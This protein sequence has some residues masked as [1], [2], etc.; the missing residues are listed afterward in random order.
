MEVE[1]QSGLLCCGD[2]AVGCCLVAR[3]VHV[4]TGHL[5]LRLDAIATSH[6]RVCVVSVVVAGLDN[7]D[8]GFCQL[9]L[10]GEFLPEEAEGDVEVAVEEPAHEAEGKHVAALEDALGVHPAVLK[11]VLYHRGEGAGYH[12]VGVNAHL[13]EVVFRLELCFLQV[14]GAKAVGVDD[15]GGTGLGV[16]VLCLQCCSIHGYEHVAEVA[17]R[18]DL[19]CTD[20]DLKSADTGE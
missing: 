8:V 15:D 18:I 19:S 5:V 11:A 14:L 9:G 17:W 2:E 13:A 10:L 20:M 12:S 3:D 16:A 6:A 1:L 7:L 4:A